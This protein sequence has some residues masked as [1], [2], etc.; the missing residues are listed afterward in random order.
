[1]NNM[2]FTFSDTLAGYVQNYDK[3]TDIFTLK[4][5]DGRD[6]SVKLKSN[7]YGW[8]AN[9]LEEPRQWCNPDQIRAML[10]PG[11]Y[12]FIYGIYYPEGGDFAYEVQ[13]VT[14]LGAK[15][16]AFGFERP[17]WWI[18]QI[19]SLGDFYIRAQFGESADLRRSFVG[20]TRHSQIGS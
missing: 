11:R 14:F 8:I 4:T 12:M 6:Y 9:N 2:N 5:S 7:T 3:K 13:Y 20:R 10:V 17:D 18:K 15:E 19:V 16:N 1:M